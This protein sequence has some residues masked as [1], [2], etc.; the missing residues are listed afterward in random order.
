MVKNTKSYKTCKFFVQIFTM[1]GIMTNIGCFCVN[2]YHYKILRVE[3]KL[4]MA[5]FITH[6]EFGLLLLGCNLVLLIFCNC[7]VTS[8]SKVVMKIYK[9]VAFFY[10][11][12]LAILVAYFLTLYKVEFGS[13]AGEATF[14]GNADGGMIFSLFTGL[15]QNLAVK[16]AIDQFNYILILT[17]INN[18]LIIIINFITIFMVRIVLNIKIEVVLPDPPKIKTFEHVGM[19]TASLKRRRIISLDNSAVIRI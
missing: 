13:K 16:K 3:S 15:S 12:F 14:S 17:N 11:V 10:S 5:Y 19:S 4:M 8:C 6:S 18:I 1:I 9:K 7:G 2:F